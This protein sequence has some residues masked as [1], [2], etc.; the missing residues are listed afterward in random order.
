MNMIRHTALLL[1]GILVITTVEARTMNSLSDLQWQNRI[2]LVG[3]PESKGEAI[4]ALNRFRDGIE[5]RD[6]AWFVVDEESV[7]SNINGLTAAL[8]ESVRARLNEGQTEVI[9]IG[10]DGGVKDRGRQLDMDHLFSLIDSMPMRIREMK[11]QKD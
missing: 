4:E 8:S 6:I 2:I 9:L 1:L 10:K 7:E 5:E 3:N 11:Q